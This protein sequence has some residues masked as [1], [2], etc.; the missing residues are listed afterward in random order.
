M[1][2]G[3]IELGAMVGV[4]VGV[5]VVGETVG[6]A[7]GIAVGAEVKQLYCLND[8]KTGYDGIEVH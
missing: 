2:V 5:I 8:S 7:V 6:T 4:I 1:K 3:A